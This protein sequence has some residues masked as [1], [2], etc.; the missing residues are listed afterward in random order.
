MRAIY[1]LFITLS[2][3]SCGS[4]S[5]AKKDPVVLIGDSLSSRFTATLIQNLTH[6]LSRGGTSHAV[7][8][9]YASIDSLTDGFNNDGITISRTSLKT[10]NARN[11]PDAIDIA[12]L[13][14][15]AQQEVWNLPAHVTMRE[16]SGSH[17]YYKPIR[18]QAM[19]L[20]CH[21]NKDEIDDDV[22]QIL[23]QKYPQDQSFGYNEGDFRGV[24]KVV[25]PDSLLH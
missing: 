3:I 22:L 25:I 9:C 19:C 11:K 2:V 5:D 23:T 20:Q 6:A 7:D 17:R 13:Q 24:I 4:K 21:G 18:V 8:F 14:R 16:E 15:I 12:V 1:F 10:R